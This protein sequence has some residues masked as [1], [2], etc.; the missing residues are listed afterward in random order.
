LVQDVDE[1]WSLWSNA[2]GPHGEDSK[3]KLQF[4][5][6]EFWEKEWPY[7]YLERKKDGD[8]WV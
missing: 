1:V 3:H 4:Y 6:Y 7:C 2:L 8:P 5:E